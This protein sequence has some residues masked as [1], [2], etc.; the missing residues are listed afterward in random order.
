LVCVIVQTRL[1]QVIDI[2]ARGAVIVTT[3]LPDLVGSA[4]LVALA[5]KAVPGVVPAL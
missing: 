4:T 3:A 1:L 2:V 5:E